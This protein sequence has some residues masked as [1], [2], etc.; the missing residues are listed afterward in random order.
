MSNSAKQPVMSFGDHLEELRRRVI[1]SLLAPL[2]V[3]IPSL[4]FAKTLLAILTEPLRNALRAQGLP[5][6]LQLLSPTEAI[7]SYFK[8]SLILAIIVSAPVIMWQ[9]WK[10]IQPGLYG[11][12]RRFAYLLIPMSA[13]LTAIGT[14]FLFLVVLPLS[15]QVL[16]AFAGGMDFA[17]EPKVTLIETGQIA[18][19]ATETET[20]ATD[21][22]DATDAHSVETETR[23]VLID[24]PILN[25]APAVATVGEMF[26]HADGNQ[27]WIMSPRGK[28]IAFDG[29]KVGASFAQQFQLKTYL[30][31]V[32]GLELAFTIAFQLPLVMLLLGWV[33]L[34]NVDQLRKG[35]RYALLAVFIAS[36]MLTPPDVVSQV[37]LA[38]PLYLLFE[39]SII[40]LRV[41]PASRVR[42]EVKQDSESDS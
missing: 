8:V 3:M 16:I 17:P 29:R 25:K 33:G 41:L 7:I 9:L 20:A 27:L 35:R 37:T 32:L 38:L 39:F 31:F 1:I 6:L 10:F 12:E 28:W 26:L 13:V 4:L 42:G 2:V 18:D 34:V 24:I 15:L 22:N 23:P 30:N 21:N 14:T 36:A 5:D 40:L 11:H 19:P